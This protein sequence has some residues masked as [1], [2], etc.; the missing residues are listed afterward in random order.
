MKRVL[1]MWLL[2]LAVLVGVS[3]DARPAAQEG[4]PRSHGEMSSRLS[5]RGSFG[6]INI[7]GGKKHFP[8]GAEVSIERKRPD[9]V[10]AKIHK[11]WKNRVLASYDISIRHGG[12][13]WQP[14]AGDPVR[15]D[16]QLDEPVPVTDA[17]S[18]GVVHLADDGTVETLPASR[19]G[20]TYNAAR[21]AVTA[22]WFKATGFSVYAIVDD[23]GALVT[24]RRFYHFYDRPTDGQNSSSA[25]PYLYLDRSN[26][27]VNV[28]IVKDGDWLVEPPV[29]RD[30]VDEDGGLIS[31]F[32]GWYVVGTNS[33]DTSVAESKLDPT[34]TPFSFVW[35]VGVTEQRLAFTNAIAFAEG[36]LG[37]TDYHIVPLYEQARFVQFCEN[38]RADHH[39]GAQIVGRKL[40]ALNNETGSA[41]I[42]VSDVSAALKNVR[43]EY[44]SGWQYIE[45]DGSVSNLLV[46]S[47]LGH[48]QEAY[49]V[50]DDALFAAQEEDVHTI[51]MWPVYVSAHFLNF[52]TNAKGSGATY[53]GSLF[54]RST[55]EI[56]AVDPSGNRPGYDFA[57]WC[58]GTLKNGKVELG[59]QVSDADGIF[60]P[61]VTVTNETGAVVF[62][63]DA[64][65]NIRL[66]QD[67][68]LYASWIANSTAS[69]RV[70]VWQQRVTDAKDAAEANKTYYY[71]THYTS[72]EFSATTPITEDL[73]TNFSGTRRDGVSVD[74]QDLTRL[75]GKADTNAAKE[76]FTGFHY[77][78]YSCDDATVA[79]DG[80]TVINVY[81]DRDLIT[82]RFCLYD[83]NQSQTIYTTTTSTSGD[84]YGTD[85]GE[86]YFAV[87]YY[88][89]QWY[90]TRISVPSYS[91]STQHTGD[92]YIKSGNSYTK[93]TSN[94]G[95]QY[96]KSGNS[97]YQ[98]YYNEADGKWYRNRTE[99]TSYTYS[100][101]YSGYRYTAST[102]HWIVNQTMTGLYGQTL[103]GNG[104]TWPSNRRWYDG[105]NGSSTSGTQISF[106][107]AF[108]PTSG[109]DETFYSTT[110]T[111]TSSSNT[112][113]YFYKENLDGT[114]LL[115]NE[116]DSGSSSVNFNISDKYN[117]F[118]AY[119][120]STDGEST[121]N[122]VG[123]YNASTGYYGSQ[124]SASRL[125][126]RFRR[127]T[128]ELI[129]KDGDR[130]V[131]NTG[132]TVPYEKVL[133]EYDFAVTN[134]L[135]NWEGRDTTAGTFEGWYEDAS[136]TVP[137]DFSATMPDGTKFLYA[138]WAPIKYR[139]IID[140]NGGEMQSGD[141]T[142]FYL[143]AGEKVLE[144]TLTRN[145]VV[146]MYSGTYYYHHDLWNPYVDKH[147]DEYIPA[148]SNALRRA[149]YTENIAE[150]TTNEVSD[151]GTRYSFQPNA[152]AF[153]GW[154]E[155]YDDGTL[156]SDPFNFNDPPNRPIAL[157]AMWRRTGVYTLRYESI[158]PD[159]VRPTS[160]VNDPEVGSNGGYIDDSETTLMKAS[161]NY[162]RDKW[163]WEGW[164]AVDV[165][166]N[167]I[168]L[169]T[170]R[171]P[172]D[173]YIVHSGH[174]D[175]DNVIHFRAVYSLREAGTSSHIPPVVDLVLDSN[176]N[177]GL[178]TNQ[179]MQTQSGR[180]GTYTDGTVGTLNGLN[181][182]VWFAGQQNNFSVNL[183]DYTSAFAHDWGYFL[184]GWDTNRTVT[185]LIPSYY[186]NEKIG[187]D[188]S[189]ASE[190]V[191][192]AVWEPHIYIEFVN[193]T[194][195][196]L[197][198]VTLNIPAWAS[199]EL[200]R[201]NVVEGTYQRSVFTDFV[202]GVGTFDLA[203]GETLR[204]VLPDAA[205]K[206]FSVS[207]AN[208]YG[209]G[210]KLTA[211][212]IAPQ[213]EGEAAVSDDVSVAY[214][215]E[216]YLVTG[217]MRVSPTPVQV[218]FTKDTYPT[219][220]TVPVRYFIHKPD[221]T[222]EA[223]TP[224]NSSWQT[225]PETSLSVTATSIDLAAALSKSSLPV[226]DLLT[227]AVKNRYGHT[228]IGIGAAE[229]AFNEFQSLTQGDASG[230]SFIRFARGYLEWSR[231]GSAWK[232]YDNAAVYVVFYERIPVQVTVAK[233]VV[234]LES[235]KTREFDFSLQLVEHSTSF[236]YQ[237]TNTWRRSGTQSGGGW[238]GSYTYN[239]TGNPE[240][241]SATTNFVNSTID[242]DKW[243]A[244]TL[245]GF[246]LA[247]GDQENVTI[248]YHNEIDEDQS[249]RGGTISSSGGWFS[250]TYYT[251][252]TEI[253]TYTVTYRYETLTVT[254][255]PDDS[256]VLTGVAHE[257]NGVPD[258]GERKY[259][260][261]S[262]QPSS[263]VLRLSRTQTV[264]L[265]A[266]Q[267]P[268]TVT[269]TNTHKTADLTV[270]KTVVDGVAGDRFN[271]L[272]S[273]GEAITGFDAAAAGVTLTADGRAL[274]FDL[275]HGESKTLALPVGVTYAITENANSMYATT[276]P[277]NASG[278]LASGG[279]TVTFVNTHKADLA[280]LVKDRE[281]S[282][283]GDEL[284]GYTITEASGAGT[285]TESYAVAGLKDGDVLTVEN[286]RAAH[287]T[288]VGSYVGNFANA[289]ITVTRTASGADVTGEYIV[290]TT[291]GSLTILGTPIVVTVTGNNTTLTYNGEVQRCEG[292]TY[293][294][295]RP[296]TE[297]EAT[298]TDDAILVSISPEYQTVQGQNVGR[299]D[300]YIQPNRV[301]VTLPSGYSLSN[302]VVAANGWLQIDP[303][304]VTVTANDNEKFVGQADP[305]LGATATGL[306][307]SD[308]V[309]YSVTRAA[310]EA[311]G[312]YAITAS[313]AAEQGNY[314]VTY[315]NGT[316]TIKG[317]PELIQRATGT[318]LEVSVS[319]TDELLTTAGL[320]LPGDTSTDTVSEFLNDFDPNGLRRWE[321][322]VTGTASN[323][324]LLS[325]STESA[326]SSAMRLAV[327]FDSAKY[328][329]LGYTVLHDLRKEQDGTWVRVAG[330]AT[331]N[332]PSFS[333]E[334]QDAGGNSRNAS[335]LY[336]VVTLI[337]P[338]QDLS[339]TNEIPSTNIIGVLEVNNAVSNTI[340]AVPWKQLASDP[341]A[342]S[343]VTVSNL[344]AALNLSAGD[345]VY[346]LDAEQR[347][348]QM[349][350]RQS[351]G[352]WE[353]VTTVRTAD[354]GG[355]LALQA[356]SA[357][358]A[359]LPRGNAVWVNRA[360]TT[361][362]YFLV[363]QYDEAEI[364]VAVPGKTDAGAG[365]ALIAIPT[366]KPLYLN[367][368]D[369]YDG[370]QAYIDWSKFPVDAA[371]Q[372][373]VPVNGV[374][375]ALT[376]Q[377]GKWGY[378]VTT[379]TY[380]VKR[381]K[382]VTSSS[383][384]PYTGIIPAGTG[385]F[386]F[387]MA[388][389]G[390]TFSWK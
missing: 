103:A 226:H 79:A 120:Y 221:G 96:R 210:T 225:T 19:Y 289:R 362:P 228:T 368:P 150:A 52:D 134:A 40:V 261:S 282:Y 216:N 363:G 312:T 269:F 277:G 61:N 300:M 174:A 374:Q 197:S 17:S 296:D 324:F 166:N 250:T 329:D 22:F 68:T 377:S 285:N 341:T 9:D 129:Y 81:Y 33:H 186:V 365:L 260:V 145:Y 39:A 231:Y 328:A 154:Y 26:D 212:R 306:C 310:G 131:Y 44:F 189:S 108:L 41:R 28:Q 348:Y 291:P 172:G 315:V 209:V 51:P 151:P 366:F 77:A 278:T 122:A 345:A 240:L 309:S 311:I 336:R 356:E 203:A 191:L 182:G 294:L 123:S 298:V 94:E 59:E 8:E 97:Y 138:K 167:N 88:N 184:L 38:E 78:R 359:R 171:S 347:G 313:G 32:E 128:F 247:A 10:K 92:R 146:D 175:R 205:D 45:R 118:E 244:R 58:A 164:Q 35:P 327:D 325:T 47:S 224:P 73:V 258:I 100:D 1:H 369:D 265:H 217:Q 104:Y 323:Q 178:N 274:S 142:W 133:A 87:Y 53:I 307:G 93:T 102:S 343:D 149:Y 67:V 85:D 130:D 192:Y 233:S 90:K 263:A 200:F 380:N 384:T 316:F 283:N 190:N 136:L 254:E 180:I 303:A 156:A 37:D 56:N 157:R 65:G 272:V 214:A 385:F 338:N 25:Y 379:T 106:L 357:D 110:T 152:Y 238:G 177:A 188:R 86:N 105:M 364:T 220:T 223:I 266:C 256:F 211:T 353:P 76:D 198:G 361:K 314:T 74:E 215:G 46:Y 236:V 169:T 317:L 63:T 333:I 21:T 66:N 187:I 49:L 219:Q 148:L 183:S 268:D 185:S 57:G 117:G 218:V 127:K 273:L 170:I 335:G 82:L 252:W 126:I 163:I 297:P 115:A 199:A 222:T 111:S 382:Y 339:I 165:R 20:F 280:I 352:I 137:F 376:Y 241:Q 162:D 301:N 257:R 119:Q 132:E 350:N 360:D 358:V 370:T 243:T 161:S 237:V 230:G 373:R 321:N 251:N 207:G 349:W 249:E 337:V 279:A 331:G 114:W 43:N 381:K 239:W 248:Y 286:Y 204:L 69:F 378:Y 31:V 71:A 387:R 4:S 389:G 121:W 143:D 98:I 302:I 255:S 275:A 295:T 355:S 234:G 139:V 5:R 292:Y 7:Q 50:V 147:T 246:S 30:I 113:V 179:T 141:S 259:T 36:E 383:F 206:N 351:N 112:K 101:P 208:P 202:E 95:T 253:I 13:K 281:L 375:T 193:N 284:T 181:E 62:Y 354:D 159:G 80:S 176:S 125:S 153:M 116:F 144:Y 18:L 124:V 305:T 75:S 99:T 3:A 227:S 320:V 15:V 201:V 262:L 326:R 330:P 304:P 245:D 340:T 293:V 29:P 2:A 42:K 342:A 346:T 195:D 107:D 23:S 344:V 271:F 34:N 196:D 319:L 322:L 290:S 232:E 11:G 16:M 12:R 270:A 332:N 48:P 388:S 242:Q 367:K 6:R 24:P 14:D 55:S 60:L 386:Y 158:D 371:D 288:E 83:S 140:P 299:Y 168:P 173:T 264:A 267:D 135:L 84:I 155:V 89:G 213:I 64:S 372:I 160:V 390:F 334:L 318:G 70:I 276:V 235:D 91:Y 229:G 72:P 287:G 308:T 194:G 54:I 27:V 109:G